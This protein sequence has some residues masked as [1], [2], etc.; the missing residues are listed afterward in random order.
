ML[1]KPASQ[2]IWEKNEICDS[3]SENYYTKESAKTTIESVR[4]ISDLYL[5]TAD[6][7]DP[8]NEDVVFFKVKKE[9]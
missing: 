8:R 4:Q 6:W 2:E 5:F 1:L 9:V 3:I 7:M